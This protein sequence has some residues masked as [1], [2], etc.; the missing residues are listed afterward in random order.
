MTVSAAAHAQ[1]GRRWTQ[2]PCRDVASG[3]AA[4]RIREDARKRACGRPRARTD[5]RSPPTGRGSDEEMRASGGRTAT[6]LAP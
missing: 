6:A 2:L 3:P 4:L 1:L 5:R